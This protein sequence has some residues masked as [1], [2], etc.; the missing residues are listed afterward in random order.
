V[1]FS[2]CKAKERLSLN[3][4]GLKYIAIIAMTIDHVAHGFVPY[5]SALYDLMRFVGRITGPTMFFMA[6]EGYRH[7]RNINRYLQR[8]AVFALI[9]WLPFL[10]FANGGSLPGRFDGW[11]YFSVIYTI[12]LGVLAMHVR[13]VIKNP[14]LKIILMLGCVFLSGWGDWGITC[15]LIILIFDFCYGSWKKQ[16]LVYSALVLLLM[17]FIPFIASLF[18]EGYFN[19]SIL[20]FVTSGMFI[21]IL[22]LFFY[23]GQKGKGG[24][25]SKWFFYV[26]YPAHLAVLGVISALSV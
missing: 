9:S 18:N 24:A 6:V 7:T 23:N 16:A 2:L 12:F 19:F 10:F 17:N 5:G 22:L 21:P 4:N 13:R 3:A 26:Y 15:V 20:S 8:L 14:A 1:S 11:I 25:F